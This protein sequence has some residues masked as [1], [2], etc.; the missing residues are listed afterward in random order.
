MEMREWRDVHGR[1]YVMGKDMRK[2]KSGA[3]NWMKGKE[4]TRTGCRDLGIGRWGGY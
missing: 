1:R 2:T 3:K 4:R